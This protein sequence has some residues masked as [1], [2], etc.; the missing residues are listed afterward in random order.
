MEYAI[1]ITGGET[2]YM[3]QVPDLEDC[4]RVVASTREGALDLVREEIKT[5]VKASIQPVI[6]S[7]MEY[8]E[9]VPEPSMS[10]ADAMTGDFV[11]YAPQGVEVTVAMVEVE[12]DIKVIVAVEFEVK[13]EVRVKPAWTEAARVVRPDEWHHV[14]T[15]GNHRIYHH[16]RKP[17]SVTIAGHPSE[18]VPV[19]TLESIKK[20]AGLK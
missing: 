15:T 1:I 13:A 10:L 5:S 17:G 20:Q 12:V 4:R 16:P 2:G 14:R 3:A 11:K 8:N 19:K 7:M 9:V 18:D 6:E